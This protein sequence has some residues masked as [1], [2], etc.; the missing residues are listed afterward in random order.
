MET[1]SQHNERSVLFRRIFRQFLSIFEQSAGPL[2]CTPCTP[3]K[4]CDK[5]VTFICGIV[6]F[7]SCVGDICERAIY[8]AAGPLLFLRGPRDAANVS[9]GSR[10]QTFLRSEKH[11]SRNVMLTV[12]TTLKQGY[13]RTFRT[14]YKVI[15]TKNK[16]PRSFHV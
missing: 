3:L 4:F 9:N 10:N 15:A 6:C 12:K 1:T 5:N 8:L 11:L 16:K 2:K 14:N 13:V 7:V